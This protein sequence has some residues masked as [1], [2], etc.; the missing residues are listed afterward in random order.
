M[1][2]QCCYC[3]ETKENNKYVEFYNLDGAVAH[4]CSA[5]KDYVPKEYF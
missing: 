2:I 5:C 3:K 1:K 4:G